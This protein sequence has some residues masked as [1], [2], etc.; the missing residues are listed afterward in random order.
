MS[1]RIL[2]KVAL[3]S[4]GVALS[5]LA[6]SPAFAGACPVNGCGGPGPVP[7]PATWAMLIVGFSALGIVMRRRRSAIA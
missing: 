6:A 7:E 3:V 5:A 1:V 4:A 2:R